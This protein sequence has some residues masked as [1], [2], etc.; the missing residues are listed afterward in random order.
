[1]EEKKL[2]EMLVAAIKTRSKAPILSAINAAKSMSPP[3]ESPKIKDAEAIL[4]RIEK[5][6]LVTSGLRKACKDRDLGAID[7]LLGEAAEL[8]MG[9]TEEVKQAEA[10]KKRLEEEKEALEGL[11]K[12]I[13]EKDMP[14]LSVFIKMCS[15]MGLTDPAVAQGKALY[16]EMQAKVA[17]KN[18]L[19]EAVKSRNIDAVTSALAKATAIGVEDKVGGKQSRTNKCNCLL[20]L[21]P[22]V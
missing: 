16:E 6:E 15:E 17:A 1:M 9:E 7:K 4:A 12:A 3:Y 14:T 13:D 8:E 5:E 2:E 21:T 18:A 22:S 10:L 20:L 19:D 11:K